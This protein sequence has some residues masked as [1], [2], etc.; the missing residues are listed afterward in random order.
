MEGERKQRRASFR[1]LAQ[2]P[3]CLQWPGR[4]QV[5]AW[6]QECNPGLPSGWEGPNS[7]GH[8]CHLPGSALA[9]SQNQELELGLKHLQSDIRINICSCTCLLILFPQ[10]FWSILIHCPG[11]FESFL[12]GNMNKVF[13]GQLWG[14]IIPR[15]SPFEGISFS[16]GLGK[17]CVTSPIWK[18]N[19]SPSLPEVL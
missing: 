5:E 2:L 10:T 3:K 17:C 12:T 8:H 6:S 14:T 1:P 19:G 11:M 16:S 4:S 18:R 7:L 15:E 13:Q 9:R